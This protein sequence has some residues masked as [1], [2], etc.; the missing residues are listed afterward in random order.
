MHTMSNFLL[1]GNS[2][3]YY[4]IKENQENLLR[5]FFE[6]LYPSLHGDKPGYIRP[7]TGLPLYTDT[8][9]CISMKLCKRLLDQSELQ[10]VGWL[11]ENGYR[12]NIRMFYP[13]INK[14]IPTWNKLL[15]EFSNDIE[16]CL[17][18]IAYPGASI[19]QHVGIDNHC[20]R[21]HWCLQNNEGFEFKIADE[22]KSWHVGVDHM[23]RFDDGNL[24]HGVNYTEC[25][26]SQPRIVCILDIKKEHWNE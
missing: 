25:E 10:F 24:L 22:S 21:A 6:V 19:S 4:F 1:M 23:F 3:I 11:D 26:N 5:E 16:Q 15:D 18:N 17:F 9:K 7:T 20:Y 8:I 13:E 12:H 14:E 2:P